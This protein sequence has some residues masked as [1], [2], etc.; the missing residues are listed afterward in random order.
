MTNLINEVTL[1]PAVLEFALF[2]LLAFLGLRR[3]REN[4]ARRVVTI[5][6]TSF[7]LRWHW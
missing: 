4:R 2:G 6:G 1:S 3:G 7:Q 5:C